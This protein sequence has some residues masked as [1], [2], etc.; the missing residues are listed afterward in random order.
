[1]F[2]R[3]TIVRERASADVN[4]RHDIHE[5][6]APTD[7]SIKLLREMESAAQAKIVKSVAVQD[8]A[9]SCVVQHFKDFASDRDVF[10]AVWSLNGCKRVT[11]FSA[12]R[13]DDRASTM[14]ALRDKIAE[15]IATI[16]LSQAFT[17]G[18]SDAFSRQ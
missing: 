11:D 8:N 7:A 16:A 5:H 10:R 9:F 6:R 12:W 3:T 2:D 1:M 15:E 13:T 14:I 18:L 4:V 17:K